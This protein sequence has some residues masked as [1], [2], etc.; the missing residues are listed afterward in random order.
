MSAG[1]RFGGCWDIWAG[2]GKV[3]HCNA[4]HPVLLLMSAWFQEVAPSLMRNEGREQFMSI[5]FDDSATV[6]HEYPSEHSSPP[7]SAETPEALPSYIFD[8]KEMAPPPPSTSTVTTPLPI[9]M[10]PRPSSSL[11]IGTKGTVPPP[12]RD[13]PPKMCFQ[14]DERSVTCGKYC[15]KKLFA[16]VATGRMVF[17]STVNVASKLS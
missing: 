15:S 16:G 13:R 10:P 6:I 9:A 12:F 11:P 4:L 5:R 3:D 7:H 17:R 8:Q 2:G 1:N 14:S